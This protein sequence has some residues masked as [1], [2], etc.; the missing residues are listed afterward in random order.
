[1]KLEFIIA[2]LEKNKQIKPHHLFIYALGFSEIYQLEPKSIIDFFKRQSKQTKFHHLFVYTLGID[3]VEEKTAKTLTQHFKSIENFLKAK[4]EDFMDL[5]GMEPKVIEFIL[6]TIE[7][8]KEIEIYRFIQ[9]LNIPS[10]G[11]EIARTLTQHFKSIEDFLAA[12][13]EDLMDLPGV[14]PE[15]TQSILKTIEKDKEIE[16]YRFIQ[17][18]KIRSLDKKTSRILAQHFK[19]IEDF[20]AAKK[21][22]LV[23]LLDVEPK[24]IESILGKIEEKKKN[25]KI[26][27][28]KSKQTKLYFFCIP[29]LE[30]KTVRTLVQHFKSI[31]NFLAAKKEDLMDLPDVGPKVIESILKIIEK[32]KQKEFDF[33]ICSLHDDL[34]IPFMEEKTARA[35]TQRFK[36]I[37][38]FLAAKKE[39]LMDL[40]DV[41]PRVTQSI[42]E[43][44]EKSK[45]PESYLFKY[46]LDPPD[47]CFAGEQ[48]LRALT[49]HFKSIE[50]FLAAKREDFIGLPIAGPEVTQ[51]ILETIEKKKRKSKISNKL[52]ES[53]E[54]SKQPELH[55]F[56]YALGIRFVGEQTARTL[57]Q[58]FKSI[59]AFLLANGEDLMDLPDVGPEVT[60]SI[61]EKIEQENFQKEI[62]QL[63]ELGVRP[64]SVKTKTQQSS[65]SMSL[66]LEVKP[67]QVITDKSVVPSQL[68]FSGLE[69]EVT[70]QDH[71]NPPIFHGMKFVITGVL[72]LPREKV[73]EEILQWGGTLSS[74]VNKK[75]NVLLVGD[76]PGSKLEKAEK[77]GLQ[78]WG[79]EEFQSQMK[80]RRK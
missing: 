9:D 40:P 17:N 25:R 38:D 67:G 56:I 74:S 33:F 52:L 19:S 43:T 60:K 3:S 15:V 36:S 75:T 5:P 58:H 16:L 11:E 47:I 31:E 44:I 70:T 1:M 61:L 32:S 46:A 55:R 62:H 68:V 35:L 27:N 64:G 77:L 21:E 8:S 57:A 10:V 12:K 28:K 45:Q 49:Q 59:E 63:L 4:K 30:E 41:G 50:T 29:F 18:L 23:A 34:G 78:I 71:E 14:G 37:E 13:K 51:S 26:S 22:N 39:D 24:V 20:L 2:C 6:K 73:Q 54:K 69:E 42:L 79:W 65:R 48:T 76:K 66:E 72:P 7:K 53:I 80:N